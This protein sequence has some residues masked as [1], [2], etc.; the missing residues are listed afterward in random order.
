MSAALK[1]D[2]DGDHCARRSEA[3]QSGLLPEAAAFLA[4]SPL[5]GVIGGRDVPAMDGATFTTLD[6]GTGK[7]VAEVAAHEGG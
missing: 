7:P 3:F 6:P 5:P 2:F 1:G 4:G